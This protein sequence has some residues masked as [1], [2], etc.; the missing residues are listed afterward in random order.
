[1]T[2]RFHQCLDALKDRLADP[3]GDRICESLRIA[4]EVGGSDLGRLLRTLSSFLR[5][6]GRTRAELETRQGWVV[7]AARLA[8]AAPWLLL[9]LLSLQ[10]RAVRAFNAPGGWVVLA[11]GAA[12][13]VVAYRLML[14][15]GRLPEDRRVLR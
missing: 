11:V 15:L 8:V 4:R 6:D 3:T 1:L 9:G 2:G 13:C 10:T 14:R 7:N 12:T 5:D